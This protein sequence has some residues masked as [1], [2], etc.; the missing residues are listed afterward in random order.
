[1]EAKE[2]I[3]KAAEELFFIKGYEG[4]G[5]REIARL[6]GVNSAMISYYFGGKENLY[7]TLL[8]RHLG[9]FVDAVDSLETPGELEFI[10]DFLE[11]YIGILR[12]RGPKLSMMMVKELRVGSPFGRK[13][14]E[15]YLC[16]VEEKVKG[17]IKRAQSRGV[18]RD[19]PADVLFVMLIHMGVIFSV[20]F[21]HIDLSE[22]VEIA[23]DLFC[24]GACHV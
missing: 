3:L 11:I 23:F 8:S 7:I 16:R 13:I 14:A 5:I 21:P 2:R 19:I 15:R 9:E 12:R 6:A 22:A 1:M 24:R 17:V 10:R 4:T 18:I 20:R